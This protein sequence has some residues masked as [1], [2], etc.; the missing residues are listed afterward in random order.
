M[1]IYHKILER[2]PD[3]TDKVAIVMTQG[4]ND[5]E[6]WRKV[7]GNQAHKEHM[8]RLFKDNASS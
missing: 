3:W 7:I 5:P 4:N 6:E 8:A 2:R 1:K